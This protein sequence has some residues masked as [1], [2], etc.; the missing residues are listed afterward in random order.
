MLNNTV[1]T[2]AAATDRWSSATSTATATSTWCIFNNNQAIAQIFYGNGDGTFTQRRHVSPPARRA[3]A[4]TAADLNGDGKLDLVTTSEN[5]GNV[6]VMLGNGDGTFQAP[7]AYL[8]L[9]PP[10]G[11]NVI[12]NAVTVTNFGSAAGGPLN[13]VVTASPRS[14]PAASEVIE[15]P[16]NGDGTFGAPIVLATIPDAGSVVAGNF[17]NGATDL[18]VAGA[19]GVTVIYG[20]PLNLPAN[21]T[22]QK[23]RSLGNSTQVLTQT[24]A[25]VPGFQ[26]AFYTYTVPTE[27]TPNS[28]PEVIDFST[29]F[30]FTGG[31]GLQVQVTEHATGKVLGTGDRFRIVVNQGD[32]LTIHVFGSPAAGSTP[33][34]F[35]AYTLDVDVLPQVLS[36]RAEAPLPGA[37]D[38]S[39]VITVQGARL[40]PTAA[41]DPRNYKVIWDGQDGLR[42]TGDD[43]VIPIAPGTAGAPSVIYDSEANTQVGVGLTFPT[44]CATNDHAALRQPAAGRRLRGRAVPDRPGRPV[45]LRRVVPAGRQRVRRP[46]GRVALRR[47]GNG[48]Q[49][50]RRY[51]VSFCRDITQPQPHRQRHRLLEPAPKRPGVATQRPARGER[52]HAGDHRDH[53]RRD[54]RPVRRTGRGVRR[55]AARQRRRHLA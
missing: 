9:R 41:E 32:E 45:Q 29:L 42:G 54:R 3:N 8:A 51:R 12:V 13:L 18:A 28:G 53:R 50:H 5:T 43:Q 23:A 25:I 7:E 10:T 4:A 1:F 6:Y 40:D 55:F 22:P 26:D 30:Q 31:T 35:G 14:D 24:A 19:G 16:G 48:R 2:G 36:V 27:S 20:A 21:T 37:G 47:Q 34:G 49:H 15:L 17:G 38:T 46:P 44:A 52:R 33:A 11:D 39:L